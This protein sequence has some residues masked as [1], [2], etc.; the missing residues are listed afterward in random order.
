MQIGNVTCSTG[1]VVVEF[2]S[3]KTG[4]AIPCANPDIS[5]IILDYLGDSITR[6]SIFCGKMVTRGLKLLCL[7][8]TNS[9][10]AQTDCYD[11]VLKEFIHVD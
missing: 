7:K 4:K 9:R 6:E 10:H 3:V 1:L 8:A 5:I 11:A 2:V